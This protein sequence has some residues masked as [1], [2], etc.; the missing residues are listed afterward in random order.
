MAAK[1]SVIVNASKPDLEPE[2]WKKKSLSQMSEKE[3]EA[4]CDGCGRCCLNKLEDWDTG[5]IHYTNIACSLFDEKT[6]RCGDYAN[7]FAIVPDCVKLEPGDVGSLHWLPP[8][9]GYRLLDE[10]KDLPDWHPLI[11]GTP[12]TVHTSGA[13]VRGKIVSEEGMTVEDY[14]DHLVDWVSKVPGA[15]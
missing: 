4:V 10:G 13:S 14:E 9:C 6:C 12:E 3:W 2:F 15:E 7:R 1:S 8:S 11:S 5:E